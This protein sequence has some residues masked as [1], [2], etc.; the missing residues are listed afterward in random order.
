MK[1]TIWFFLLTML[2]M[3]A[4][5]SCGGQPAETTE[6]TTECVHDMVIAESE[7]ATCTGAGFVRYECS[8]CGETSTEET[9]GTPHDFEEQD[10]EWICSGCGV[11]ALRVPAEQDASFLYRCEEGDISFFL[12]SEGQVDLSFLVDG[13]KVADFDEA[14]EDLSVKEPAGIHTLTFSNHSDKDLFVGDLTMKGDKIQENAILL[15]TTKT[16]SGRDYASFNVYVR[17]SDPS[18]TYYVRY[19]FQ[20]EYNDSRTSYN[21]NTTTNISNFRLKTAQLVEVT[22]HTDTSIKWSTIYEVLQQGEIS[23]AMKQDIDTTKIQPAALKAIT[24]DGAV[25]TSKN[26]FIGGY[27]GDERLSVAAVTA[28]GKPVEIGKNS[29]ASVI[30]CSVV[31]FDQT[32]TL[33]KWGTSSADSFGVPAAEHGQSFEITGAG[34]NNRQTLTWIADDFVLRTSETYLQMFTMKRVSGSN[35][36]C[37]LLETFDENG[38]SIAKAKVAPV[39]GSS[40]VPYVSDT[41]NRSIVYGSETSGV[42]AKAGFSI[43]EGVTVTTARVSAR[44]DSGAGDNKWYVSFKSSKNGS[45]PKAGEHWEWDVYYT[46][47]YIEP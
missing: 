9:P 39:T 18:G 41:R 21:A 19:M 23:L 3:I 15:E 47:D 13:E 5:V 43:I 24:I 37:D 32:T 31:T 46:I 45:N 38:R 28:D 1:K 27:H 20:Y 8:K 33:Y 36:V 17:T 7:P 25:N 6:E 14:G 11:A 35:K 34:I 4:L 2:L 10:G 16:L 42:S 44:P 26:D 30:E 22:G 40:N 29:V 12:Q